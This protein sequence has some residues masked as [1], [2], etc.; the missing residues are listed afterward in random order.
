MGSYDPEFKN[1]SLLSRYTLGASW[2]SKFSY[3]HMNG[4]GHWSVEPLVWPSLILC[5][6]NL[7]N[8]CENCHIIAARSSNVKFV[9][10]TG[11]RDA[12]N[13]VLSR[14]KKIVNWAWTLDVLAVNVYRLHVLEFKHLWHKSLLPSVFQDLLK[15]GRNVHSYNTRYAS[16]KTC[17]N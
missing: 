6:L 17:I 5:S 7:V 15:Y 11:T 12:I 10:E 8:T 1:E 4:L 13:H 2:F 16:D 3:A 14:V 9:A